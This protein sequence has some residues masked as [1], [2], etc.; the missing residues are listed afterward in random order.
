M[1]ENGLISVIIPAFNAQEYLE[2]CV[3]SVLVQTYKDIEIILLN[4]GS[5][6]STAEIC[7]SFLKDRRVRVYHLENHGPS[8]RNLGIEWSNGA[9]LF[10]L[11]SDDILSRD[12]LEKLY[13]ALTDNK[14][15]I[16]ICGT[17]YIDE[18]GKYLQ[19]Y[20]T[21]MPMCLS[22][23]EAMELLLKDS[24]ILPTTPWGKLYRKDMF[25]EIRFPERVYAEDV[26]TFYL[27]LDRASR[28][29]MLPYACY[30]YRQ[31][32]GSLA[33]QTFREKHM[34]ALHGILKRE[35]FIK[36]KYSGLSSLAE[37][38]SAYIA[39]K[40]LEALF[41]SK[42]RNSAIEAELRSCIK[43]RLGSLLLNKYNSSAT[44][45]FAL[46]VSV[47]PEAVRRMIG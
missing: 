45:L 35:S 17:V 29:V 41:R 44:K 28:I 6:D 5:T 11:D 36:E 1:M 22:T 40:L 25:E 43:I 30:S 27:N 46:A 2:V 20:K 9:Y 26:F 24:R 37:A 15:D 8:V 10:F 34:D 4:D 39:C 16:S 12:C 42:K 3:E 21:E 33:H 31:L 38:N 23:W 7:D 13:L 18:N 47:V 19:E 32:Q 14:A